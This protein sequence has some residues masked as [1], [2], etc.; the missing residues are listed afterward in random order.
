[1]PTWGKGES[2]GVSEQQNARNERASHFEFDPGSG[3]GRKHHSSRIRL[4]LLHI[5]TSNFFGYSLSYSLF[6]SL[7]IG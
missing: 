3:G 2:D 5:R 7:P 6:A 1:M 4:T